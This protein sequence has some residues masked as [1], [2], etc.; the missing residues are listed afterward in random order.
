MPETHKG[1]KFELKNKFID[2][3]FILASSSKLGED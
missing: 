2:L 3:Y 1:F